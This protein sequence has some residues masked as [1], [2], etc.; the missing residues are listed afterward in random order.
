MVA[1]LYELK[2]R[3][4]T[5][6]ANPFWPGTSRFCSVLGIPAP[7]AAPE[8]IIH[9]FYRFAVC[10]SIRVRMSLRDITVKMLSGRSAS[11]IVNVL[12]RLAYASWLH[13]LA[14]WWLTNRLKSGPGKIDSQR[15]LLY[16][17]ILSTV[18]RLMERRVISPGVAGKSALL[19]AQAL[20]VPA[21]KVPAA[22]DFRRQTGVYPPWF[23]TIG[24]GHGC[25]LECK[26]CY[27]A[28]A[29]GGNKLDWSTLERVVNEAKA[30]W[31]IRL[32]VFSG[33]EPLFYSSEGKGVLDIV[34]RNPDLLF[35][36]FT[37]GTLVTEEIAARLSRLG[38]LTPA[39]S[40]EG[41]R[42]LTDDCRGEGIFDMV[43]DKIKLVRQV[44]VPFGVSVSVTRRNY[45]EILSD[46]FLELF[47]NELGAFYA[48]FFQYLPIGRQPSF[49]LMPTPAQ[50]LN[51]W[52]RV[53]EVVEKRHLF[54]VDFWNHGP[55]ANG[56]ISAGRA[57]GYVYIDWNGNIMPCVFTPYAAANIHQLYAS[58]GT[59]NDVWASPFFKAIRDWQ[60]DYGY[61]GEA[62]SAE[63]NWLSPC[64][65]RDHY[66][67]F[68][69]W[70]D[71]YHPEPEDDSARET[72]LDKHY[73]KYMA[74]YGDKFRELSQKIWEEDYL[75]SP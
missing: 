66:R 39:F 27:A 4:S 30:L 29:S 17:S 16:V 67:L 31:G 37:N 24:P 21:G 55:L 25:N 41:M 72:L 46:Q 6:P 69:G 50:R 26:G 33:G 70:I 18:D 49:E 22:E 40:V 20:L 51:F 64:P 74:E 68:R 34:E 36:M 52:H 12:M 63:G 14:F 47:F 5:L 10:A 13:R 61:G 35:L 43:I 58:G 11:W 42:A 8:L 45:E 56:C 48:F 60:V 57:S 23:I 28:S 7:S 19:W 53:W 9:I 71:K 73:Y 59:L 15:K 38:N 75:S 2:I 1:R 44:G 54:L 3:M 32:V 65:F 62:L